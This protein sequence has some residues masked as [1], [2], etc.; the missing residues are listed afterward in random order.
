[1]KTTSR[2]EFLSGMGLA[3]GGSAVG[4]ALAHRLGFA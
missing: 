1:M 4:F 2:R 3:L